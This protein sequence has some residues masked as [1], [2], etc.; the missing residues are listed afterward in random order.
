MPDRVLDHPALREDLAGIVAGE[1]EMEDLRIRAV[2]ER[3]AGIESKSGVILYG[4]G[5]L[6]RILALGHAPELRRVGAVFITTSEPGECDFHGF[7]CL[8][9]AKARQTLDP[10][11][12]VLMSATYAGEMLP[13]VEG[14]ANGNILSLTD[15]ANRAGDEILAEAHRRIRRQAEE[16]ASEVKSRFREPPICY[17]ASFDFNPDFFQSLRSGGVPVAALSMRVHPLPPRVREVG[18]EDGDYARN[19]YGFTA[20]RIMIAHLAAICP[21]RAM[22]VPH[23][24][25]DLFLNQLLAEACISPL[26]LWHDSFLH[27]LCRDEKLRAHYEEKLHTDMAT[28]EAVEEKVY[29]AASG[30][31]TRYPLPMMEEYRNRHG[32]GYE[33][34]QI[35]PPML[36]APHRPPATPLAPGRKI[37]VVFASGIY[38][39]DAHQTSAYTW[40]RRD[41][42]DAANLLEGQGVDF[43]VYNY[44]DQGGGEFADLENRAK[45][46]PLFHYH[47]ALTKDDLLNVLPEYDFAWMC[48]R[49]DN[50][51][52][53]LSRVHVNTSLFTYLEAGVPVLICRELEFM[54]GLVEAWGVGICVG[55][56]QWAE[57]AE[58]CRAFDLTAHANNL[59]LVQDRLSEPRLGR[60]LGLFL[61]DLTREKDA[62]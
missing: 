41:I 5:A 53:H 57:V 36:P 1:P 35:F 10:A 60:E 15:V 34:L 45:A 20:F 6:S 23:L 24:G 62:A 38:D 21:F 4:C 31:V 2:V 49:F 42:L 50:Y 59:K 13:R 3:L 48:R 56:D 33:L 17:A 52:G 9:A 39:V 8:S 29:A 32:H 30:V 12:V 26:I 37:R 22:V 47:Q 61:R 43:T 51:E 28:I 58:R 7:P 40:T 46:H 14:M 55:N 19:V 27:L 44:R 54:A 11:A 25:F 16:I 18:P